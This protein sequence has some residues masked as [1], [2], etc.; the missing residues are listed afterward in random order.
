MG[1][2]AIGLGDMGA[3]LPAGPAAGSGAGLDGGATDGV[4]GIAAG[5]FPAELGRGV[6]GLLRG[7]TEG[8]AVCTPG[9]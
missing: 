9:G 6:A 1:L 7:E 5:P 3:E 4:L 8:L 2:G